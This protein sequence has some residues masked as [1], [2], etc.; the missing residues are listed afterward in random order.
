M[1]IETKQRQQTLTAMMPRYS[2]HPIAGPPAVHSCRSISF[3]EG[4]WVDSLTSGTPRPNLLV[5]CS[6]VGVQ[7]VV[8]RLT[9]LFRA[10]FEV[11]QAPGPLQLPDHPVSTLLTYDAAALTLRQQIDLYDWITVRGR[12]TQVISITSTPLFSLV[13]NGRFLESLFHRLS[14]VHFLASS[15]NVGDLR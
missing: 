14:V 8:T 7:P 10:P 11:C 15:E 4:G 3:C 13:E 2:E 6:G 5:L 9:K 12:A 1:V